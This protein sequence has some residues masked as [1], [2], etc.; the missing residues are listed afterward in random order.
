MKKSLISF[1]IITTLTTFSQQQ[2]LNSSFDA[3]N[4]KPNY[5]SC[6]SWASANIIYNSFCNCNGNVFQE[7]S[8][9]NLNSGSSSLRLETK[10]FPFSGITPGTVN[11]GALE[12]FTP[13]SSRPTSVDIWYKYSPSG[14][15]TALFLVMLTKWNNITQQRDDVGSVF[16][17]PVS[18]TTISGSFTIPVSYLSALTPDSVFVQ[19]SSSGSKNPPLGTVLWVDDVNFNYSTTGLNSN[20]LDEKVSVYPN[21]TKSSLTVNSDF[22]INKMFLINQFGEIL[23]SETKNNTEKFSLD[24]EDLEN[25]MYVLKIISGE[26]II[27]KKIIKE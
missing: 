15:D 26:K 21:P 11:Y 20:K 22:G 6:A 3:W 18:S 7:T 12:S 9:S 27:T 24:I 4:N 5:D 25:G 10:S 17:T 19:I 23:L 8:A 1:L 2:L 14:T 13:F 16:Y